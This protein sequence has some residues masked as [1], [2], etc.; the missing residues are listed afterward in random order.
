MKLYWVNLF[1]NCKLTYYTTCDYAV[2][3]ISMTSSNQVLVVHVH[4]NVPS[5]ATRKLSSRE[6]RN[7][8]VNIRK[9]KSVYTLQDVFARRPY[10]FDFSF[11]PCY[12]CSHFFLSYSK[13]GGS[14]YSRHISSRSGTFDQ[15]IVPRGRVS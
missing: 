13:Q 15:Q 7:E 8:V 9:S 1:Y 3:D 2:G 5:K 6:T 4:F 11:Y 14:L 12:I 10:P